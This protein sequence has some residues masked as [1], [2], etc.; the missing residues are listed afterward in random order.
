MLRLAHI[1]TTHTV[2]TTSEYVRGPA[3][4]WTTCIYLTTV[5]SWHIYRISLLET[6]CSISIYGS[7][8][9][10]YN[11]DPL[12]SKSIY[13]V[14]YW[15]NWQH[16]YCNTCVILVYTCKI[17]VTSWYV[18]VLYFFSLSKIWLTLKTHIYT[19]FI[20]T[21]TYYKSYLKKYKGLELKWPPLTCKVWFRHAVTQRRY[22]LFTSKR[23][24]HIWG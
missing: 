7:S 19:C 3:C 9:Y 11:S 22:M 1:L 2:Y 20:Q 17:N 16:V 21:C 6:K 23:R 14:R 24:V 5:H 13:R 8:K 12:Q 18:F 15:P 4:G 10:I